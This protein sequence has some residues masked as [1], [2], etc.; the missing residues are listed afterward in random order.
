MCSDCDECKY[1]IDDFAPTSPSATVSYQQWQNTDK[2]EKI[3]VIGKVMDA[4]T[5]LNKKI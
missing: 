4:F 5:E 1:L 2:F 3:N